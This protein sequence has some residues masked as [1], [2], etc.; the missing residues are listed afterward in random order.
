MHGGWDELFGERY[1][2]L[3]P[4]STDERT[5]AEAEAAVRLAGVA[6]PAEVLDCPCGYG[7]H[8]LVLAQD[9][10]RVTGADRSDAQL[11][12]AER[13]RGGAHWPRFVRADYRRLPFADDSFD[14]VLCLFTSLGYLERDGDV[15]V[16]A[17]FRRVL[18]PGGALVVE[19]MH[20][21]RLA[22]AFQP[23][24]WDWHPDGGV[25]LSE[26]EFDP[27]A[28]TVANQ[29]LYISSE[30]ERVSRRFVVHVYTVTEWTAIAREAGF[31]AVEC[32][33]GWEQAP[34]STTARLVMRAR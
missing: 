12:E 10:Y 20:R 1:A 4:P 16:L 23:R 2:C 24:D 9:G 34:P 8:A 3:Y 5:R 18:R 7:R 11:A 26:R 19:V 30:G 14:A 17:E 22:S 15:G 21:D 33:G 28:G 25:I 32:F 31:A 13:R 29:Q 6:P 27:V